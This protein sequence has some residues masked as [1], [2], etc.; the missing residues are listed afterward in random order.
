MERLE[1]AAAVTFDRHQT[2]RVLVLGVKDL[3]D[4]EIFMIDGY[5]NSPR[6]LLSSSRSLAVSSPKS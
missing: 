5:S 6:T 2:H 4:L 1:G 3:I